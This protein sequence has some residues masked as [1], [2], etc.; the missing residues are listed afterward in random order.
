MLKKIGLPGLLALA[1]IGYFL[2]K[3]KAPGPGAPAPR[4]VAPPPQKTAMQKCIDDPSLANCASATTGFFDSLAKE[5]T[6][7]DGMIPPTLDGHM[8]SLGAYNGLG[9]TFYGGY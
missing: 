1:A 5:V 4:P 8:A 7:M 3:P 2:L 9:G 6:G